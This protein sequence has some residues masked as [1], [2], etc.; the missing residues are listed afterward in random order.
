MGRACSKQGTGMHENTNERNRWKRTGVDCGKYSYLK[1]INL[2]GRGWDHVTR[3]R[4]KRRDF[5]YVVMD[6]RVPENSENVYHS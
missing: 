6:L 5:I 3:D 1:E 4:D 2:E